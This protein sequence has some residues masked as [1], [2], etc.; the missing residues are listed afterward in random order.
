MAKKATVVDLPDDIVI[1]VAEAE[2]I[3]ADTNIRATMCGDWL[4][5]LVDTTQDLGP[6]STGKMRTVASTHGFQDLLD[7]LRG[8]SYIGRRA[9]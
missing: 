8:N 6:S 9:Q 7:G 1:D 3:G 2:E 4:I 5:L